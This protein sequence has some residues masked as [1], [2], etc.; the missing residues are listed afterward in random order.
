MSKPV[1]KTSTDKIFAAD[2][3]MTPSAVLYGLISALDGT[4]RLQHTAPTHP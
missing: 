2:N 4:P 3:V 1:V